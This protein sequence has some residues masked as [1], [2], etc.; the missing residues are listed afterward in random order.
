MAAGAPAWPARLPRPLRPDSDHRLP[1][2]LA[3]L[4][5]SRPSVVLRKSAPVCRAAAV[6]PALLGRSLSDGRV[7]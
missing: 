1:N 7:G 4:E 6:P 2:V 5:P 3:G